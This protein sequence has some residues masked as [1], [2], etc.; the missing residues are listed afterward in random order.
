MIGRITAVQEDSKAVFVQFETPGKFKMG[1]EV[2]V[3]TKK[4]K[5]TLPQNSL[6]WAF[7]TWCIHSAGGNLRE[8]G[9]FST[10]ALH[11]DIKAWIES[12]HGHDFPIDKRFSTAELDKK[13]FAEFF[14]LI[15][16]ELMVEILGVD[17]S[18][19]WRDHERF[20]R[21]SE[22][23]NDDMKAYLDEQKLPF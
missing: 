15:S 12:E 10:D 4:F 19:F 23:N 16:Q 2:N 5:R 6:Y 22:Y 20:T 8:Q 3:S 14:N 1:E 21:W 18:G 17:T 7:L 13:Q 9:H 11:T